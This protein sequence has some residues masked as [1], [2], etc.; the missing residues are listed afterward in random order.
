[1]VNIEKG[2]VVHYVVNKSGDVLATL[3]VIN[4]KLW[5]VYVHPNAALDC[6]ALEKI[7]AFMRENDG[8]E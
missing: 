2:D 4:G 3:K 8:Y 7:A 1:M 5:M 6:E